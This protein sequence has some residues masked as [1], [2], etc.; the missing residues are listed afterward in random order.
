MDLYIR[1]FTLR[2]HTSSHALNVHLIN[3]SSGQQ[4]LPARRLRALAHSHTSTQWPRGQPHI[5]LIYWNFSGAPAPLVAAFALVPIT[6]IHLHTQC[7]ICPC[8]F[9][10]TQFRAEISLKTFGT[11]RHH[12]CARLA[13][14]TPP[15]ES[16]MSIRRGVRQCRRGGHNTMCDAAC[17][18]VGD[19]SMVTA[20]RRSPFGAATHWKWVG[21]VQGGGVDKKHVINIIY[22]C[23][24]CA[25]NHMR[26]IYTK[27]SQFNRTSATSRG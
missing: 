26:H 7:T 10:V 20:T 27:R 12:T 22:L 19:L 2:S 14:H 18:C 5:D 25:R 6:Y 3:V 4:N 8:D 16:I 21:P 17:R 13:R 23:T 1:L 24:F 15:A 9:S 11:P